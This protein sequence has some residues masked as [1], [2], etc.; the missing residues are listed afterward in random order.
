MVKVLY[1][2]W[3]N[4]YIVEVGVTFVIVGAVIMEMGNEEQSPVCHLSLSI[5]TSPDFCWRASSLDRK[6]VPFIISSEQTEE[7]RRIHTV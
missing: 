6:H 5:I 7:L 2:Y 1:I 3:Q 4:H